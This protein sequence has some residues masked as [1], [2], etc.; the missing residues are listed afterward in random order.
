MTKIEEAMTN[1]ASRRKEVQRL[2]EQQS[3]EWAK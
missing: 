2:G 3:L 1:A